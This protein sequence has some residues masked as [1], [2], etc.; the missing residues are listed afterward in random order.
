MNREFYRDL[1]KIVLDAKA[2]E[3]QLEA[4]RRVIEGGNVR[5]AHTFD[6]PHVPQPNSMNEIVGPS[7]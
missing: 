7:C 6:R 2:R 3:R 4:A 5:V 1:R